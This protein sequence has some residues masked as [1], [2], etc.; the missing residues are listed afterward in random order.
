[1]ELTTR[2]TFDLAPVNENERICCNGKRGCTKKKCCPSIIKI[3][4]ALNCL[5][6]IYCIGIAVW[7]GIEKQGN[8]YYSYYGILI[9]TWGPVYLLDLPYLYYGIIWLCK[10]Q[11]R[12][13]FTPVYY[14]GM[15]FNV[16]VLF[17][18]ISVLLSIF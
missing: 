17:M 13:S 4:I 14:I 9:A 7:F 11:S 12:K 3:V 18:T 1:M 16:S 5:G 2:D 10:G 15:T 8:K 6:L